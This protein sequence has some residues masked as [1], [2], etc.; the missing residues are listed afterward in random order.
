MIL[1]D[2]FVFKESSWGLYTKQYLMV[3]FKHPRFDMWDVDVWCTIM[4]EINVIF[5]DD[6]SM[7]YR[8]AVS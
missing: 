3:Y 7:G 1:S 4:E 8:I 6:W 2:I 5:L